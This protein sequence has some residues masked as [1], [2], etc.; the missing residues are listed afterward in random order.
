MRPSYPEEVIHSYF[1]S[2]L[3]FAWM[4]ETKGKDAPVRML[5]G[6]GEGKDT[7]TLVREVLGMDLPSFDR[8]VDVY[9]RSRYADAF[10]TYTLA[11]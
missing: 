5:R 11:S 3:V 10:T 9:V 6:Y 4:E 8:A 7:P 1:L 2:A